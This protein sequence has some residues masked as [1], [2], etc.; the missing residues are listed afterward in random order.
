MESP[1]ISSYTIPQR[2]IRYDFQAVFEPLVQARTAAGVLNRMPYLPQWIEQV[3]EEQLRLEAAGTSRIEGA[4]F[5][6][7]EQEEALAADPPAHAGL[8]HS[9]RQLRAADAT[10]RWMRSQPAGRW[11]ST[12]FILETHRRIVTGC[13]D[14][15]CEPGALR[16]HGWNVTFGTPT[17]RGAEGGAEC[18]TAFDS[19][20]SAIGGEFRQHDRIIQAIA[21][22]Y[23]VGSMHPFGDG[24]GRT[25]RLVE[26]LLLVRS[27]RVPLVAGHLLSNHYNLTRD[28]YYRELKRA[29]KTGTT[30]HLLTYAMQGLVDGL[31][32]QIDQVRELQLEVSWIN[33]VHETMGQFPATAA[34]NRQRA[35]V[36]AMSVG[37]TYSRAALVSISPDIAVMY[38]QKGPRTLSRDLN[39]LQYAGLLRRRRQGWTTN[40]SIMEAFLPP[41]AASR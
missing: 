20:C 2:W 9:Q 16:P 13:D 30:K 4:E 19:L 7:G 39:R 35:L 14:D 26:F 36:L 17:C 6:Q 11:I 24:N 37:R 8:T 22:H 18:R 31:R 23:H 10:Y 33:F 1:T 21:T 40:V 12:D 27:G 38:A 34:R 25:A 28:Q 41:V 29:S 15:H 32:E 5:T 3:H